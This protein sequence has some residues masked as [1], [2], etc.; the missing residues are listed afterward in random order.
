MTKNDF[1]AYLDAAYKAIQG[2]THYDELCCL[3]IQQSMD[4]EEELTEV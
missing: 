4:M 1:D 3:L 2:H